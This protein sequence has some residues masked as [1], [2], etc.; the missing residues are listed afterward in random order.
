M[1]FGNIFTLIIAFACFPLLCKAQSERVTSTSNHLTPTAPSGGVV[2]FS[3][4]DEGVRF[5]PI[6]GLDQAWISEQNFRKGVNHMGASNVGIARTCFRNTKPLE[7]D[8]DLASD[9]ISYLQRRNR[10]FDIL[11]D[12]L[13]LVL[14]CDQEAGVDGYYRNGNTANV[15]RWAANIAAHVKW[16][17]ER[18]KH[19][20]TGVSIFN[21]P[22]YWTEEGANT[23][24]SRDIAKKLK[25]DY[26]V[27]N[28]VSIVGGNTL[29]DD[30]AITWYNGGKDYYDWGNTHQ[31]AGSMDNYKAFYQLLARD[32]KVGYNDEMHN[33]A[34]AFIGLENGMTVGIWWG[35]DSRARGEFCDISRHGVRLG[36]ADHPNNWTAA[37][38]YRHDDGRVKA[39]MGSSERQAYTTTYQFVCSDHE[40]YYDG[41]G[42][43][44]EIQLTMHGGTGYQKGQ[45]NAERVI[46]V[47]WGDDVQ[48]S[49]IDGTYKIMNKA[50]KML[51]AEHGE[52]N[53]NPNI[54]QTPDNGKTT[55]HWEVT[56][57]GSSVDGDY[58]FYDIKS[59]NDGKHW[60]V[61]NF[62]TSSGAN[63]IS[64]GTGTPSTNQSWY[65]EYAGDGY[66]YIRNR[67]SA[68]YLTLTA[69]NRIQ[70]ININ[71]QTLLDDPTRQLWRFLP[72]D[73]SC[74]TDAP[75]P[76]TGLSATPLA[77]GVLLE[78]TPGTED[79][80]DGYMV[81]R[82][83]KGTNKWH[84]I[85]RK[86]KET[87]YLDNGCRQ[88]KQYEYRL[89]AIDKSE[90]QSAPCEALEASP[91]SEPT[92]TAHY[93]FNGDLYDVT[94]HQMDGA[95]YGSPTF[96]ASK[97]E[98]D[99]SLSLNG[100]TQFVQLPYEVASSDELTFA[101]WV[102][103][104][105]TSVPNQRIFDFGNGGNQ[106][107]YLTPSNGTGVAFVI[108]D[109][110]G[111]QKVESTT[112]L[113]SS[114]WK[115]VAVSIGRDATTLYVDGEPVGSSTLTIRPADISTTLNY[116]GRSQQ[117]S[118]SMLKAYLDDVRIYN[119]ALDAEG[120]KAAMNAAT[121][122]ITSPEANPDIDNQ[123]FYGVDGIP[124]KADTHK[125]VIIGKGGKKKLKIKD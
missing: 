60:D 62:S 70:G 19:R 67:E 42:P 64:F 1:R 75:A 103:W 80:L 95:A 44:R 82:A 74:E 3:L 26:E 68:L 38:V 50:T 85:A 29:N 5:H 58:S 107:A 28:D 65:L 25:S 8:I 101:A 2:P 90:N 87:K 112:K 118:T 21:E 39:F 97:A 116:L 84:T 59:V 119:H 121:D 12:T 120:V 53:G 10:I 27:M 51:V 106:Y 9:P 22:D 14:T 88:G 111:E 20:V 125:G 18:S 115:H 7:N 105:S 123:Q 41:V 78:W 110:S 92:L 57:V 47:T 56:P 11:S 109:G 63:V 69:S 54:A 117:G 71:Q 30:K 77:A 96:T 72:L 98:G 32:G 114:R 24:N 33:V 48:P 73:A 37:T 13:A 124:V 122:H 31:L 55:T 23:S 102:Y 17:K 61:L 99:R 15:D 49:P 93:P 83:E 43:T 52:L 36:Y 108:N 113:N 6:W 100:T 4:Y 66:Y 76:P 79:D 46:D 89:K 81:Q 104:R 34:E 35:F 86:V 94:V 91:T 45:K 40:V 16:L